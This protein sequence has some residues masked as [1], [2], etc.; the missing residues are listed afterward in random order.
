MAQEH[1]NN[2]RRP[3]RTLVLGLVDTR[4]RPTQGGLTTGTSSERQG[5]GSQAQTSCP[6]AS[7]G[8]LDTSPDLPQSKCLVNYG[9]THVFHGTPKDSRLYI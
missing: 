2:G 4:L 6:F 7:E 8:T 5:Y 3:S 1:T 9:P